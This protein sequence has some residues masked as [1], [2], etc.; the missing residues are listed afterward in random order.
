MK[1][2]AAEEQGQVRTRTFHCDLF[3]RA[4]PDPKARAP[5]TPRSTL[6][7]SPLRPHT[8]ATANARHPDANKLRP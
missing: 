2:R 7:S 8:R 3:K 4:A 1:Q 6:F 5:P